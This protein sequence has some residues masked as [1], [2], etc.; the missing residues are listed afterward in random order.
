MESPQVGFSI[1]EWITVIEIPALAGLLGLTLRHAMQDVRNKIDGDKALSDTKA[2]VMKEIGE[3]RA[4]AARDLANFRVDAQRQFASSDHLKA[5]E[6]RLSS[7]LDKIEDK[8]D[9]VIEERRKP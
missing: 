4:E 5:L 8:L 6:D 3:A 2:E 1:L 7:H 9:R